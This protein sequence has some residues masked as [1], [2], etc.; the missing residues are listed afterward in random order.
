MS[1]PRR[2]RGKLVADFSAS[3]TANF[4]L[5]HTVNSYLPELKHI[6][7]VR[8]GHPEG[9]YV[10]MLRLAG[11]LSTFSIEARPENLPDYDH[12]DLGRCFTL[13]DEKIRDLIEIVIPSKFVSVPLT[14]RDRFIWSG[15]VAEDQYFRNS[16][17]FLAVSAK[18][19]VDDLIQKAPNLI[20]VSAPD[21]I[22]R[23]VKETLRGLT[24]RHVQVPPAAIPMKLE[25]QYFSINQAGP[26][27]DAI[28]LS[29]QIAV[30]APGE[31]VDPKMEVLVVLE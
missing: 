11:A 14:P 29:R 23:L 19:G 17:F 28:M 4:W 12:S 20:K 15:A 7:R 18:M 31:I 27:W 16:Q 5:L 13:L 10:A 8:Q 3:E 9:A 30:H 2:Q 22:Q 1:G 6:W 25:N 26:L 21:D 24:L